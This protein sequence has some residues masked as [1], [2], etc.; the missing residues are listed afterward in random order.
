MKYEDGFQ[1]S[2]IMQL[3]DMLLKIVRKHFTPSAGIEIFDSQKYLLQPY[4]EVK[5]LFEFLPTHSTVP[6]QSIEHWFSDIMAFWHLLKGNQ[7]LAIPIIKLMSRLSFSVYE[8]DWGP[9]MKF[10]YTQIYTHIFEYQHSLS[11]IPKIAKLIVGI[12]RDNDSSM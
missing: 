10:I 11:T 1:V 7:V 3:R 6:L 9:Y 12:I 8:I 5:M 4:R 2:N